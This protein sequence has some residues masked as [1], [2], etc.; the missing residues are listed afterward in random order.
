MQN[1][2]HVVAPGRFERPYPEQK[3]REKTVGATCCAVLPPD[4]A[5]PAGGLSLLSAMVSKKDYPY[6]CVCS[7][8]LV[9]HDGIEP[10]SGERL[11]PRIDPVAPYYRRV[12]ARRAGLSLQSCVTDFRIANV[13]TRRGGR[14]SGC[15]RRLSLRLPAADGDRDRI[16]TG[17]LPT[18]CGCAS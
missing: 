17:C 5:Q 10:P 14:L 12:T 4:M 7:P 15:H 2:L 13:F 3:I 16:R 9:T 6:G 18:C 8:Q 1:L 11:C